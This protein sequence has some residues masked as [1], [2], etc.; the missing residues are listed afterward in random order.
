M[1]PSGSSTWAIIA[2]R[3]VRPTVQATRGS[4]QRP[5]RCWESHKLCSWWGWGRN[6]LW[7][8][9]QME[10]FSAL[11]VLCEGNPPVTGGFPSQRPV[12]QSFD[13]CFDLRLNE[14]LS[15]LSRRWWFERPSRSLWRHSN[16]GRVYVWWRSSAW[17]FYDMETAF[18][19][20]VR[21][22]W[23]STV[24]GGLP[25]VRDNNGELWCFVCL[26]CKPE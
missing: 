16:D 25:S 26:F 23:C 6:V 22:W 9:H 13:V 15:K 1:L 20:T 5:L 12:T 3:R 18:L 11:L 19:I 8:R 10:T 7:W 4:Y 2:K 14:R 21:L 24:T 17:W